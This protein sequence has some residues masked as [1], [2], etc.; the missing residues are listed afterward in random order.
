MATSK[1]VEFKNAVMFWEFLKIWPSDRQ[2]GYMS[3]VNLVAVIS[4]CLTIAYKV[5]S[6]EG[7]YEI[8]FPPCAKFHTDQ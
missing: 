3:L 2:G 5:K 1:N 4:S 7:E 8:F 6:D